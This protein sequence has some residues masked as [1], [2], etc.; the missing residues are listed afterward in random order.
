MKKHTGPWEGIMIHHSA[1]RETDT[2]ESIRTQHKAKGWGDIGYH[3]VL[4][5]KDGRGFLKAGRST[6][7]A[8]AHAGVARYNNAYIG[9][10]V[11]GNYETHELRAGV[12]QDLVGAVAHLCK[13]YGAPGILGHRDVKATACPGKHMPLLMLK[14]DVRKRLQEAEKREKQ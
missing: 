14:V 3:Y 7:Y 9:L 11:P 1:G 10:C 12:Y 8:G 5:I 2:V 6:E 4:E 13:K